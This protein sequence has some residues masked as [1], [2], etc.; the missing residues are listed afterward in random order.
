MR[1]RLMVWGAAVGGAIL[2]FVIGV[3]LYAGYRWY[4]QRYGSTA[5]RALERYF[6]ALGDGEYDVMYEMTPDADLMVLGRKL[7]QRDFT[8]RV[9]ELLG[10]EE[11]ELE[12]IELER[13]AQRGEYHYFR[14]A[15]HYQLGGTGKVT[16]LLVELRPV[17]EDW[18]VTYPFTPSL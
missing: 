10:G 18:K 13:I 11:M 3:G 17:G 12:E 9:E 5:E 8:S 16:R 15:L 6:T 14:A 7:S 4:Q 2:I 1:E